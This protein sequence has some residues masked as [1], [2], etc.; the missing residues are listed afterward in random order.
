M[1]KLVLMAEK[2]IR[3]PEPIAKPKLKHLAER[4]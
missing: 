3:G 1:H 4:Q 2:R